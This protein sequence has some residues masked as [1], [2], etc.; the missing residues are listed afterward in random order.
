VDDDELPP[1]RGLALADDGLE[2]AFHAHWTATGARRRRACVAAA[3][4]AVSL[5]RRP[6]R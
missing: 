4:L 1:A 6:T 2:A 5:S 3:C